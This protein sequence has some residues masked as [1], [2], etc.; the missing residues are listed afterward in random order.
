MPGCLIQD[1]TYLTKLIQGY[2][3]ETNESGVL[4]FADMEKAFDRCSWDYLPKAARSL[5]VGKDMIQWIETIYNHYAPPIRKVKVNGARGPAFELHSGV[6]QGDPLS[7]LVFVLVT[8]ALTRLIVKDSQLKGVEIR[9]TTHI[10]SQFADDSTFYL[11]NYGQLPRLWQILDEWCRVTGM[12]LNRNKT[13]GIV[14]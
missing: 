2:L 3:D 10:I 5:G 11:K 1:C 13:E 4:I 12:A 7:P 14:C 8:E 9:G 6:P